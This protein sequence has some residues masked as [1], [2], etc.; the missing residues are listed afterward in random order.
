MFFWTVPVGF[1]SSLIALQNI[2]EVVPFLEPGEAKECDKL[3]D[4]FKKY[5]NYRN[6]Q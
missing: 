6:L 3:F 4:F 5:I 2:A 1:I